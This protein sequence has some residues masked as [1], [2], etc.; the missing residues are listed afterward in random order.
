MSLMLLYRCSIFDQAEVFWVGEAG[1]VVEGVAGDEDQVGGFSFFDGGG[2]VF[3]AQE[4]G[5]R[6]C[7]G[8]MRASSGEKPIWV[9]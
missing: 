2:F 3:Y 6:G 9:M 8:E 1:D 5:C 7:G 4:P